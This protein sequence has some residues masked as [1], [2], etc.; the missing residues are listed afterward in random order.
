MLVGVSLAS[1]NFLLVHGEFRYRI[2]GT[3]SLRVFSEMPVRE[4]SLVPE[5]SARELS[6]GPSDIVLSWAGPLHFAASGGH[7]SII[8]QL[9][10]V[11]APQPGFLFRPHALFYRANDV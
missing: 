9:A 11:L 3:T 10:E 7:A 6:A 2:S 8:D 4:I 5:L 1:A